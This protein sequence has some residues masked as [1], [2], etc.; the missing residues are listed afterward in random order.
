MDT[1]ASLRG[2]QTL[3]MDVIERPEWVEQKIGEINDVWFAVDCLVVIFSITLAIALG[4][5]TLRRRTG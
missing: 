3:C 5:A 2:A 4:A 1:L